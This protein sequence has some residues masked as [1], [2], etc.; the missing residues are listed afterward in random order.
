MVDCCM[1]DKI[2]VA[3]RGMNIWRIGLN[4]M[5]LCIRLDFLL[6][7]A[8]FQLTHQCPLICLLSNACI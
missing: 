6:T 4:E 8:I 2:S 5:I 7:I 1:L 3:L